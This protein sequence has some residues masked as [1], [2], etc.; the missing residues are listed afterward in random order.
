MGEDDFRPRISSEVHKRIRL[1]YFDQKV[2]FSLVYEGLADMVFDE[3]GE[4]EEWYA[5]A[6]TLAEN[7][8]IEVEEALENI[9]V[10][11]ID[12]DGKFKPGA[13]QIYARSD[14]IGE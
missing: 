6:E 5:R 7:Q 10:S 1:H 4:K 13:Q 2:N 9:V 14:S 3:D 12:E 8:D 11:V